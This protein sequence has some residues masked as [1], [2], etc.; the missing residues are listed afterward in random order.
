VSSD[1]VVSGGGS[2]REREVYQQWMQLALERSSLKIGMTTKL[3]GNG[4][5]LGGRGLSCPEKDRCTN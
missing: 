3:A 2:R 5:R 4:D 1:E